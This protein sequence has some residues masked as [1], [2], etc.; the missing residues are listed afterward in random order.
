[1][2]FASTAFGQ[3]RYI[4]EVTPGVTPVSGNGVN[5]STTGPTMNASMSSISSNEI[6]AER[7]TLSSILADLTVD[8]GFDFELSGKEYDP[9]LAGVLGGTW[10][11]Y[12]T[13]GVGD[14]FQ[15][16]STATT[17]TAGAAPAGTSAF[18]TLAGGDWSFVSLIPA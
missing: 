11:H 5:L 14:S 8:G 12:G 13:Q 4:A 17:I 2:A 15:M 3:L 1:M 7:M 10:T 18:T 6:R 16:T 9:F